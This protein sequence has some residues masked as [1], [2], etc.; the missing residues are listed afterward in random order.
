[1]LHLPVLTVRCLHLSAIEMCEAV[2]Q[3]EAQKPI[4]AFLE[5]CF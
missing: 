3:A 4:Q 2:N 5:D 1:M